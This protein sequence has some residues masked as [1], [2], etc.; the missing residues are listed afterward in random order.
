MFKNY[1]NHL[2]KPIGLKSL[3]FFMKNI[4]KVMEEL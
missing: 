4:F 3:Q 1:M 2:I